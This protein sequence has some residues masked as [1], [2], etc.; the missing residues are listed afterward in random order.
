MTFSF[1][2]G[3]SI[4]LFFLPLAA[5]LVLFVARR[6]PDALDATGF[7]FGLGAIVWSI[8]LLNPSFRS[9]LIPGLIVSVCALMPY[10]VARCRVLRR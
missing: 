7:M 2:T 6:A 1:V 3:F 10:A 8:G 4:G 9:W 5:F